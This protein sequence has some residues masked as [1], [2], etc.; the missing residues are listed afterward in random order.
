MSGILKRKSTQIFHPDADHMAY[1]KARYDDRIRFLCLTN[2][3]NDQRLY[4]QKL[5]KM[6]QIIVGIIAV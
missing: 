2:R 3:G 6:L 4:I 5:V 1:L